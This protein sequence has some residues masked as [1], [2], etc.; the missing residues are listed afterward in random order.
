VGDGPRRQP[1]EALVRLL[2]LQNRVR[3]HGPLP[4]PA[5]LDLLERADLFVLPSVIASDGTME[6]LPV[7]LVEALAA[8][9]PVVATRI[10]GVP[11]L[12]RDGETG[13]LAEPG[14]ADDL[15]RAMS[16]LLADPSAARRRAEAGR[17]L[18]EQNHDGRRSAE[19]LAR[20]FHDGRPYP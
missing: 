10:S 1:L 15:R 20:L 14:R 9:V 16:R 7:V 2:G 19:V 6:G 8:G 17:T 13:L 11:E 4:E 3:F 12:I 5:V 18:V